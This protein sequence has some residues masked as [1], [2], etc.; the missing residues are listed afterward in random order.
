MFKRTASR[1]RLN[2]GRFPQQNYELLVPREFSVCHS[3]T[4]KPYRTRQQEPKGPATV[5]RPPEKP[6]VQANGTVS[7][8]MVYRPPARPSG[9]QGPCRTHFVDLNQTTALPHNE[10]MS[11]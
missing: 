4:E 9:P 6:V 11:A 7:T 10:G 8:H 1:G 2:R 5:L 3:V